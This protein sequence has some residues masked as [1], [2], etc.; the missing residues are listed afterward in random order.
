VAN[1][2]QHLLI[3]DSG[4]D[5]TLVTSI[6][7]ILQQT[8]HHVIMTGA[9]AGHNVGEHFPV[10]HAAC[11]VCLM[12]DSTFAL[13]ANHALY[14]SN[15]AQVESLLSVHQSL[16]CQAN[17]ID[18]RGKCEQDIHGQPGTQQAIFGTHV[19]PFN[20]DGSKCFFII[21]PLSQEEY[22][23]LPH[24]T[25]TPLDNAQTPEFQMLT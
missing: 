19:L 3:A 11:K 14:D 6:W 7:T 9:F 12:D 22:S 5:Q 25:L 16:Q 18:N 13:I 4:C 8:G 17:R 23:S 20:F 10:V 24:V 2:G 1:S 15:L 21:E